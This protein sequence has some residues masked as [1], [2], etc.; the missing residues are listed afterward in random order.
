[1]IFNILYIIK[2]IAPID[3]I[4]T[5]STFDGLKVTNYMK[6]YDDFKVESNSSETIYWTISL[7]KIAD[8]SIANKSLTIENIIFLNA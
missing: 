7:D 6:F 4:L 5:T 1:M 2:Q 8:N 3:N